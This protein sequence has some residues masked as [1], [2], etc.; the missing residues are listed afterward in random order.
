MFILWVKKNSPTITVGVLGIL[1]SY[2]F[3]IQSRQEVDLTYY[4]HPARVSILDS[5]I[6]SDLEVSYKGSVVEGAL[7]VA[8]VAFWNAGEL[9]IRQNDVLEKLEITLTEGAILEAKIYSKS[10][11]I[12]KIE[13]LNG[14]YSKGLIYVDWS[15]LEKN[16][17]ATIQIIYSGSTTAN[18]SAKSTIIG[19]SEISRLSFGG[20]TKSP[21]EQ[22]LQFVKE[23]KQIYFICIISGLGFFVYVFVLNYRGAK[24]HHKTFRQYSDSFDYVLLLVSL[25]VFIYGLWLA[26][27]AAPIFPQFLL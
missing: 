15:I 23:Q 21:G 25:G 4:V 12:N 6:L 2:Y 26:F 5:A 20:D 16:D 27:V 3:Y 19:Q 24:R 14:D 8:R 11:N 1:F 7:S 9:P 22:Y 13:L 10:R 17:G 18:I